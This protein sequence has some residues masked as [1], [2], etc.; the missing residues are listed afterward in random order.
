MDRIILRK[1]AS[2]SAEGVEVSGK[3]VESLM[4]MK[5]L[6]N[7]VA[8][9]TGVTKADTKLMLDALVKTIADCL[10]SGNSVRLSALGTFKV[11]VVAEHDV[12]NKLLGK[13]VHFD[14]QRRVRFNASKELRERL[15]P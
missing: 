8:A 7:S 6:I 10:V 13:T 15:N 9:D 1:P 5:D 2:A 3:E 11:G 12:D 14:E 4:T